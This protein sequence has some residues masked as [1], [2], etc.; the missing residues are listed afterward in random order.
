LISPLHV[1]VEIHAL[2]EDAN[3]FDIAVS[4]SVED[5]VGTGTNFPVAWANFIASVSEVSV[6]DQKFACLL[7]L[8]NVGFRPVNVPFAGAV[9]PD[10]F[11]IMRRQR[12]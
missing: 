12:A 6:T 1:L 2:M 11:D 4:F 5:D 10:C 7:D 3:D 9:I 8:A